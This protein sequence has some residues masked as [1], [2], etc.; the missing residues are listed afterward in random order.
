[1]SPLA[2]EIMRAEE[3]HRRAYSVG[4]DGVC[5]RGHL[6]DQEL[7]EIMASAQALVD[8]RARCDCRRETC[9]VWP[10]CSVCLT[11]GEWTEITPTPEPIKKPTLWARLKAWACRHQADLLLAVV[12]GVFAAGLWI[13]SL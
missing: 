13:G 5:S 9:R 10:D 4:F 8:L 1:M 2:A 11:C 7:N 3:R 6:T 12:P